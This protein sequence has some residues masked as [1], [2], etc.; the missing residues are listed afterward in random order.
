[1]KSH[2]RSIYRKL[3]TPTRRAAVERARDLDLL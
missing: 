1:V 3:D 2:L